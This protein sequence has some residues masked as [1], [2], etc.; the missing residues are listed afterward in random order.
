MA[1]CRT[2][3]QQDIDKILKACAKSGIALKGLIAFGEPRL[4]AANPRIAVQ[5]RT[6]CMLCLTTEHV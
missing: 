2:V 3:P 5:K 4:D 1:M 6:Q